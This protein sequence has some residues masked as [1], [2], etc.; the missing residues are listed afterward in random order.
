ML[1]DVVDARHDILAVHNDGSVAPVSEGDV[2]HRAALG[3]VNRGTGEH[4]IASSG[5]LPAPSLHKAK[6]KNKH[7][8]N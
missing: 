2:Q 8:L 7:L 3:E 5:N 4:G 1:Q 6:Q